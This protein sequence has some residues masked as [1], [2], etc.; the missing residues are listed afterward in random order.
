MKLPGYSRRVV[1]KGV[2][3]FKRKP[4]SAGR[5]DTD[6]PWVC[7]WFLST[8]RETRVTGRSRVRMECA[9]CGHVET[10]RI[11]LPRFG[12]VPTPAGGKHVERLR[13]MAAHLHADASRH[14]MAWARPLLNPD[15][16]RG[17]IDLD[18]LALRL[19]ADL[20][21]AGQPTAVVRRERTGEE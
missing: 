1:A 20:A 16:H 7:W 15:A 18:A 19:E 8:D 5:F 9:V 13:F 12:P 21:A 14:P 3:V 6:Q 2:T 17:G 10:L 4:E 11:R